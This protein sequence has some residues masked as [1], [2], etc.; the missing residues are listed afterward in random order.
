MNTL[1]TARLLYTVE[2]SHNISE[3]KECLHEINNDIPIQKSQSST[4][5]KKFFILL[6]LVFFTGVC[7]MTY[8]YYAKKDPQ[9]YSFD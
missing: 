6:G 2:A 1:E 7:V 9:V 8:R 4:D 5:S 3:I